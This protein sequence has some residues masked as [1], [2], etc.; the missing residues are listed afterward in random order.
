[1]Y[2]VGSCVVKSDVSR[3]KA[4][5]AVCVS[6]LDEIAFGIRTAYVVY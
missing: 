2:R 3:T 4:C 1:V 6:V 5:D